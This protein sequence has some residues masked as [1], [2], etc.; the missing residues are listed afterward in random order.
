MEV[1]EGMCQVVWCC[2][3]LQSTT[4]CPFVEVSFGTDCKRTSTACGSNPFW[5]EE[6]VLPLK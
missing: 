5:N 6:L 2:V 3:P 1:M 4:V